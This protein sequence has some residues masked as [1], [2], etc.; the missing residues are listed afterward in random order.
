MA[1]LQL[2]PDLAQK[3][4]PTLRPAPVQHAPAPAIT[5]LPP[6]TGEPAAARAGTLIAHPTAL[7][8]VT[9]R[10]QMS[11]GL[12]QK[13]G[14]TRMGAMVAEAPKEKVAPPPRQAKRT[15]LAAAP[16]PAAESAPHKEGVPAGKH[17]AKAHRGGKTAH[18]G[19]AAGGDGES[20]EPMAGGGESGGKA[21]A[22]RAVAI[23][24]PE[25]HAGL[26]PASKARVAGAQSAATKAATAHAAMPPAEDHIAAARTAVTEPAAEANARAAMDLVNA[27]DERPAPS[28]EIEALCKKIYKVIEA[29]RPPDEDALVKADPEAMAGAAGQEMQSSVQG[30]VKKVDQSYS[31]INQKPSGTPEQ[32][33]Q[34]IAPPAVPDA[35]PINAEHATP[36]AVPAKN[37][38]LDAD[39]ADSKARIDAAGMSSEP[40]KLAKSGPVAEAREAQG[41][42]EKSAAEDPAKV[43]SDQQSTLLKAGGDMAALQKSALAAL[44]SSRA[45]TVSGTGSQQTAMVGTEESKRDQAAAEAKTIFEDAQKD[46]EAQLTPLPKVARDKWDAGVKLASL[47]FKGALQKVEDW[48]KE[49]HKGFGGSVVGVLDDVFGLPDWVPRSYDI[50]EKQFG[51]EICDLARA[52]STDVNG[53]ILTCEAIIANARKRIDLVFKNLP[54]G[55]QAWADGEKASFGK[56]LDGLAQH[57][58]EVRD[59]FNKELIQSASEAVDDVRQQIHTLR[60]KAKGFLGRLADAIGRFLADPVKF[61]IEALLE[62]VG[63]PPAAFWAVVAKVKKV[64]KDIADDPMKF[65]NNLMAALGQGF[66][67]FLD[68]FPKHLLQ[69]FINWLTSGLKSAGVTLPKDASLKSILTFML[70]LMGITWPNIRKLLL[71]HLGPKNVALIDKVVS[72][73]SMF[74]ELGPEGVF[75]LIKDKLNPQNILDTIIKAA[76]DYM[77]TAVVKAVSARILLLFN[78]VGAIFQ[79]LEAIYRVLKWV[80][81]NAARIFTLIETVVNGVAD[82]IAGNIGGMAKAVE[83]ALAGLIAPVIDFLAGYLGFGDLPIAIADVIKG[84]QAT[85]MEVLETA[86]VWLIEKGKA[87]LEAVG[88]GGKGKK[89]GP[90]DVGEKVPFAADNESH[91]LWIEM[92]G[93]NAVLMVA[94]E[95]PAPLL[96]RLNDW[97]AHL[98]DLPEKDGEGSNPQKKAVA[99]ISE[100]R[101]L[102]GKTDKTAEDIVRKSEA[103]KSGTEPASAN[104]ET[105]VLSDEEQKLADILKPLFELFGK[106][107]GYP[108]IA[109]IHSDLTKKAKP[110]Q[111]S[112]HAP[113]VALAVALDE[114]LTEVGNRVL[115]SRDPAPAKKLLKAGEVF[116]EQAGKGHGNNLPAILVHE[117]THKIS[118]GDGLRIHGHE[119]RE[120]L[121]KFVPKDREG[122]VVRGSKGQILVNPRTTHYKSAIGKVA[123]FVDNNEESKADAKALKGTDLDK[124][125][126]KNASK[127]V[128]RVH[129]AEESRSL[130]AVEKALTGSKIDGTEGERRS[131]IASLRELAGRI[132]R[133]IIA[134]AF[135]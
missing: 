129:A 69:G 50:A 124:A 112:H 84:F 74:I 66:S 125:L 41:D 46:V 86:L 71:K 101:V 17:A 122:D 110:K 131:A 13:V 78:P 100:A 60:E 1:K 67:Q 88:L 44:K 91:S 2:A 121:Q 24:M 52:I 93:T 32:Q 135:S 37:V 94:S 107:L 96:E 14:N 25:P 7:P 132:W 28:P 61:I 89:G 34:P 75:E 81:H 63:I 59:N 97:Q 130:G 83:M 133:E 108:P 118:G 16:E 127:V 114:E 90:A 36:D 38:S 76:I 35:I 11:L 9:A 68:N 64:I 111:Q 73:V 128:E 116:R 42:L 119:I 123:G 19:A 22:G 33:G 53:V 70:Q 72:L 98:Q 55:L 87:L 82:I 126:G 4:H 120:H 43:L 12:Q 109:G 39:V 106:S 77:M 47:K 30:E 113:P 51:D 134:K 62:L 15:S 20:A 23:R 6:A 99:L 115:N 26:T 79:A 102:T 5:H 40:A 95:K 103:N 104:N 85:V 10:A 18:K 49:R 117:N 3:R 29:K 21:A 58:H 54:A 56:R 80:F 57:A 105:G 27:L 92:K 48:I 31:D 65:G 45:K 8:D